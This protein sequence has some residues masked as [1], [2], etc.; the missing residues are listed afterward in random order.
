MAGNACHRQSG[1]MKAL[2]FLSLAFYLVGLIQAV[3]IFLQKTR[4]PLFVSMIS[5]LSGFLLHTAALV[6]RGLEVDRCPI[7]LQPELFT[8]LGW[9][10]VAIYLLAN[11]RE[12]NRVLASYIFP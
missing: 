9:V 6:L 2:L 4:L 12:R 1:S 5:V 3:M 7:A 8:F 11:I 10:L